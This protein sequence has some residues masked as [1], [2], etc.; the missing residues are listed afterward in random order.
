MDSEERLQNMEEELAA[1]RVHTESMENVLKA[2][3]KKLE[4]PDIEN[5]CTENLGPK[6][7]TP[8]GQVDIKP[9]NPSEFNGDHEK[10]T[11]PPQS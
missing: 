5:E 4:I 2:I 1:S 3:M 11:S 6:K 7:S 9:A 10:R 8:S